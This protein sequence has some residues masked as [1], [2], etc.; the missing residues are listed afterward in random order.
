MRATNLL[1]VGRWYHLRVM[2]GGKRITEAL[3]TDLKPEAR[4]R[5]AE[6]LRELRAAAR[7]GTLDELRAAS[8]APVPVARIGEVFERFRA[9]VV[10]PVGAR[11]RMDYCA[12]VRRVVRVALADDGRDVDA[13]PVS[14]LDGALA[15]EF[16]RRWM[17]RVRGQGP[18]AEQG[19]R[20]SANS[21]LTQARALFSKRAMR[22]GVYEGMNLGPGLAGW[23]AVERLKVARPANY[24]PPAPE[25]VEALRA[26]ALALRADDVALFVVLMI[27]LHAGLRRGEIAAMRWAWVQGD[28][29]VVPATDGAFQAKSKVGRSV[30]MRPGL[31]AELREVCA[32][33]GQSVGPDD[34]VLAG[35]SA[36][37]RLAHFRRLGRWMR[38]LGWKRRQTSHE[39]RKIAAS[40]F[41]AGNDVF[42]AQAVLG[43][44]QL[45]TT[46]RYVPARKITPI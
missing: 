41:A 17:E 30:P 11:A 39:L 21:M 5:A 31:L 40:A 42:A 35:G 9:A 14:V 1:L 16:Q 38:G 46:R 12:Q 15:R 19:A 32:V 2:I 13:L 45:E 29:I 44:A 26:A 18:A 34:Y 23:L 37:A 25:E 3:G 8:A 22:A 24:Q 33:A 36:G 10:L 7:A 28:E 6:R 43:H 4:R 27:G 20:V